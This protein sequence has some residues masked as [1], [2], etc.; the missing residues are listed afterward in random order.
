MFSL[1]S[2]LRYFVL[3]A[4]WCRARLG[5]GKALLAPV[6]AR[7]TL[8]TS[9]PRTASQPNIRS[10]VGRPWHGSLVSAPITAPLV[11]GMMT[12]TKAVAA[13]TGGGG[14]G[15]EGVAAGSI[16]CLQA[17]NGWECSG[18]FRTSD[19]GDRWRRAPSK[20][21]SNEFAFPCNP[22]SCSEPNPKS[23][24][25]LSELTP[26]PVLR[27][28][29]S[30]FFWPRM[31]L[32]ETSSRSKISRF[33]LGAPYGNRGPRHPSR[34][35]ACRAQRR[36]CGRRFIQDRVIFTHNKEVWRA[37]DRHRRIP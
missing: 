36:L 28:A 9:L 4:Q 7:G 23:I 18:G 2:N 37:F 8:W 1:V 34:Q 14:G 15:M 12:A 35:L 25:T 20:V 33:S 10:S 31:F 11:L 19:A 22:A 5:P 13:T 24:S 26:I 6:V 21:R 16:P 29:L 30:I 27:N 32:K 17:V 3:I